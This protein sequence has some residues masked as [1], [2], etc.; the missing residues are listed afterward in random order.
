MLCLEKKT[1]RGEDMKYE[2][3]TGL[4][5][6]EHFAGIE[7]TDEGA[8]FFTLKE[9]TIGKRHAWLYKL[10]TPIGAIFVVEAEQPSMEL[11]SWLFHYDAEKALN[12]FDTCVKKI[13]KGATV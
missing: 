8:G 10:Q 7:P 12:R 4:F 11:K 6:K 1:E 9:A 13:L 3:N 5:E 2:A